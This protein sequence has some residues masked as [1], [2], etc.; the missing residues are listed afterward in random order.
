MSRSEVQQL[1]RSLLGY[2]FCL[3]VR[4]FRWIYKYPNDR[5]RLLFTAVCHCDVSR[6][7]RNRSASIVLT[8]YNI[9]IESVRS[10]I[11]SQRYL[12]NIILPILSGSAHVDCVRINISYTYMCERFGYY[13]EL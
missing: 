4:I 10:A 9:I 5:F 6:D 13:T 7:Q 2:Q 8:R 3:G 11:T 1:A 12:H